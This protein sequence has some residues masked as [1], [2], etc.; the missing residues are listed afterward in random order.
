MTLLQDALIFFFIFFLFFLLKG[1]LDCSF[2]VL[3]VKVNLD[4]TFLGTMWLHT[5]L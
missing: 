5:F 3:S 1:A 4:G 2:F